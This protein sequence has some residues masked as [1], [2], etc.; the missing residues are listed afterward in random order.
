MGDLTK[1][2]SRKEFA[3]GCGC[4]DDPT[5]DYEMISVVQN[6]VDHFAIIN[7]VD[8]LIVTVR[9][10]YRCDRWN[11]YIW[12]K[13]NASREA[14]GLEAEKPSW[15]SMHTTGKGID[16]SI[17]GISSDAVYS[18]LDNSYPDKYGIGKYPNRTHF[19]SR[20]EKARWQSST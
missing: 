7:K 14:R 4:N 5:L 16:F 19:D 1:N 13:R 6:C 11:A 20:P 10:G 18:Y 8:K 3:C 17:R 12:G 15:N 9:S 2:F